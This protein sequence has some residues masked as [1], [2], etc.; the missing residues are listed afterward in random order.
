MS[1]RLNTPLKHRGE[2]I[3]RLAVGEGEGLLFGLKLGTLIPL[4]PPHFTVS[5]FLAT[6]G[7]AQNLGFAL[8][9]TTAISAPLMQRSPFFPPSM[10][11]RAT[12]TPRPLPPHSVHGNIHFSFYSPPLRHLTAAGSDCDMA[13]RRVQ[14]ECALRRGPNP[15]H[16]ACTLKI[17]VVILSI[18]T[19]HYGCAPLS[20]VVLKTALKCRCGLLRKLH[21]AIMKQSTCVCARACMRQSMHTLVVCMFGD[22]LT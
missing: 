16:D 4:I 22:P 8:L 14:L 12:T 21:L 6:V 9:Y 15:K 10:P 2:C 20:L 7:S 11:H 5:C 13:G 1:N 17:L 19:R 3:K 18:H